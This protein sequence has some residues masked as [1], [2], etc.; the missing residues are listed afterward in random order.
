[1]EWV[2]RVTIVFDSKE[3]PESLGSHNGKYQAVE[4]RLR[5]DG[6]MYYMGKHSK[7]TPLGLKVFDSREEVWTNFLAEEPETP[8]FTEGEFLAEVERQRVEENGAYL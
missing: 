4:F 6:K 2:K 3:P 7:V 5:S 1:M 8:S